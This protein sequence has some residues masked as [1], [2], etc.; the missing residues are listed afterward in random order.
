MKFEELASLVMIMI[1]SHVKSTMKPLLFQG[2]HQSD[3]Q[4]LFCYE[5]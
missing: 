4:T 2:N 1:T 5:T 3:F